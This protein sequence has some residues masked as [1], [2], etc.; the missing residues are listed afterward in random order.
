MFY[1]SFLNFKY[2]YRTSFKKYRTLKR[3]QKYSNPN[4]GYAF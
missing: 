1:Y 4:I 3:W 2:D